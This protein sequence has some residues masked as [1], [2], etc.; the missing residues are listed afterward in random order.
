M[1]KGMY[2]YLRE[3]KGVLGSVKKKSMSVRKSNINC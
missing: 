2:E 1:S 3:G